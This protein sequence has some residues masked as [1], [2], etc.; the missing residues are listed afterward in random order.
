MFAPD[1]VGG[2]D[3]GQF[4]YTAWIKMS[5]KATNHAKKDYHLI[6][7]IKMSEF[8][9]RYENPALSISTIIN[10]S[11][12]KI[13]ESNQNRG[14]YRG[15]AWG[16]QAPPSSQDNIQASIDIASSSTPPF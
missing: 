13:M 1:Q 9:A 11:T 10:I 15:D 5:Q 14:G 16:A 8:I 2:Q 7:M 4:V 3:V 6:S 12:Q